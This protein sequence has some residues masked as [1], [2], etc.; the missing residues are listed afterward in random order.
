[1]KKVKKAKSGTSLGMKSIKAGFDKNPKI[2]R[3]DI[4]SA[5]KMKPKKAKMGANI[6]K[7]MGKCKNGC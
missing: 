3:A 4:I 7:S 2:T 1:M 5:G 6:N